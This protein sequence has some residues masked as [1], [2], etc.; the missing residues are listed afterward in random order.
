MEGFGCERY[1]RRAR[2]RW[3]PDDSPPRIMEEGG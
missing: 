3:P 1:D 2:I